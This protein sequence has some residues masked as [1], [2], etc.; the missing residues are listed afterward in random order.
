VRERVQLRL[1]HALEALSRLLREVARPR[2]WRR[3][4]SPCWPS[5]S[6]RA[7]GWAL[8][9]AHQAAGD[10]V[11]AR[12]QYDAFRRILRREIGVEPSFRPAAVA[13]DEPG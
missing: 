4:T 11:A 8:I 1:L 12:R 6:G 7:G 10:W 3:C 13:R 9:E 2:R 5:R